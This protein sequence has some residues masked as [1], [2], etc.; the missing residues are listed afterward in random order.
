MNLDKIKKYSLEKKVP[1]LREKS[2]EY[3]SNFFIENNICTL[4]EIGSGLGYSSSFFS[5]KKKD[6]KI[7]SLEKNIEKYNICFNEIKNPNINFLN[8]CAYDFETT[9]KYDCIFIDGPKSKQIDL[10][11]KYSKYIVYNGY[12]II[13]NIFL[14]DLNL[15]NKNSKKLFEKNIIFQDYLKSLKKW[16]IKIIDIDDGIAICKKG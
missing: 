6:L 3:I 16:K 5:H 10:F 12:I 13:D 1:I 2:A 4:L 11:E 14:K 9:N 8:I 15:K 7:D